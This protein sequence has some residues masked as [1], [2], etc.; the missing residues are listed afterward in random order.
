MSVNANGEALGQ[1]GEP[2]RPTDAELASLRAAEVELWTADQRCQEES[3]LRD[4]R[5]RRGW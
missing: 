5:R 1:I 3:G 2:Q 4:V